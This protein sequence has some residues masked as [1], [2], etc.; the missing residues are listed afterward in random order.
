MILEDDHEPLKDS[1]GREGEMSSVPREVTIFVFIYR[2][3]SITTLPQSRKAQAEQCV[4]CD[5]IQR[6]SKAGN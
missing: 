6:M 5:V 2:I 1:S 3:R 4:L